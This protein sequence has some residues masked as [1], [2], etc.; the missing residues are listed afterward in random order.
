MFL[1]SK[2]SFVKVIFILSIVFLNFL[3]FFSY[4]KT[5]D[6]SK[7]SV[8]TKQH[9]IKEHHKKPLVKHKSVESMVEQNALKID[10][11]NESDILTT[12]YESTSQSSELLED[13][14]K[15]DP[16]IDDDI[17]NKDELLKGFSKKRIKNQV[18]D[19]EYK[20]D[21]MSLKP[22]LGLFFFIG[23]LFLIFKL[24]SNKKFLI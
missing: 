18:L 13:K 2:T 1:F 12:I 7:N 20:P 24:I 6:T 16:S 23:V 3:I 8:K 10:E 21:T 15:V 19:S 14:F 9:K 5:N 4:S 17:L 11:D 22:W